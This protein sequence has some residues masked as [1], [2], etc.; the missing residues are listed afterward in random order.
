MLDNS[1]EFIFENN[2]YLIPLFLF[3]FCSTQVVLHAISQGVHH[4]SSILDR[5]HPIADSKGATPADRRA[6]VPGCAQLPLA[7]ADGKAQ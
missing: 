3:L 2:I 5:M 1:K 7:G 6:A 4:P